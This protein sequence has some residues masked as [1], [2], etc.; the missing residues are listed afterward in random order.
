MTSDSQLCS[1]PVLKHTQTVAWYYASPYN[2][3]LRLAD[4]VYKPTMCH[5]HRVCGL[6]SHISFDVQYHDATKYK[7]NLAGWW[8]TGVEQRPSLVYKF[9]QKWKDLGTTKG[10]SNATNI[11]MEHWHKIIISQY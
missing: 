8:H 4:L 11:K 10:A 3:V 6:V 5:I 7:H 2:G 1:I 9:V